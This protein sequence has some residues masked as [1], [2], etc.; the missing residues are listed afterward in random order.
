MV[1]RTNSLVKTRRAKPATRRPPGSDLHTPQSRS[2]L[3]RR[4]SPV[5]IRLGVLTTAG[6]VEAQDPYR[7][8]P[9]SVKRVL[10]SLGDRDER[11]G[12]DALCRTGE[13]RLDGSVEDQERIDLAA[14]I[15]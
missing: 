13:R 15:A 2:H 4:R 3:S 8:G 9:A 12:A 7:S 14:V 6:C 1:R 11:A 10:H 5:R